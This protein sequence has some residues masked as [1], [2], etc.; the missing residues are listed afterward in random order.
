MDH[1]ARNETSLVMHYRADLVDL[2]RLSEDRDVWPQGVGGEYPRDASA[3]YGRECMERS[4][5]IV[6]RLIEESGV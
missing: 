2:G 3:E 5:E 1:A 6:G 4:V